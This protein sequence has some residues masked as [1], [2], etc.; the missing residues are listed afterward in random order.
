M[1]T[2]SGD[3]LWTLYFTLSS[4]LS[5][6]TGG[7]DG[8]GLRVI[9]FLDTMWEARLARCKLAFRVFSLAS[10]CGLLCF[11]FVVSRVCSKL[12]TLKMVL[13]VSRLERVL[14]T[15]FFAGGIIRPRS[16]RLRSL[17]CG[18]GGSGGSGRSLGFLAAGGAGSGCCV[19][20]V[21]KTVPVRRALVKRR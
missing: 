2:R 17:S 7:C 1:P 8:T 4:S 18:R 5:S 16:L 13:S 21:D 11:E 9:G 12:P 3:G 10:G 15:G 6:T 20:F 14:T 19:G